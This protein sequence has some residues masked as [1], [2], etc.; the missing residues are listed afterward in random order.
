MSNQ[1]EQK[2]VLNSKSFANEM[3]INHWQT[4]K[5]GL[6]RHDAAIEFMHFTNSKGIKQYIAIL[7]LPHNDAPVVVELFS[8]ETLQDLLSRTK[9]ENDLSYISSVYDQDEESSNSLYNLVWSSIEPLLNNTQVVYFVPTGLLYKIS[10]QSIK[11]NNGALI[12]DQYDLIQMNSTNQIVTDG[13]TIR[14]NSIVMYGGVNYD[15]EIREDNKILSPTEVKTTV[16]NTSRSGLID[17]FHYLPGTMREVETLEEI[18]SVESAEIDVRSGNLAT[19][20]DFKSLSGNSPNVIHIST[21][22]FFFPDDLGTSK[23][24]D[25]GGIFRSTDNPLLRSG[26]AFSGANYAW[27]HGSNPHEE[28]DGILTAYEIS[29]LDLS[30]TDLV[31]LSACETGLGK[32]YGSEGVFGLQRAFKMA[33]VKNVIMS[34][35]QVNDYHT[36]ELMEMFYENWMEGHTVRKALKLA[37][38]TMSKIYPTYYWGAF[39]IVG[40]KENIAKTNRTRLYWAAGIF[41]LLILI[42]SVVTRIK[43][44]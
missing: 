40:E 8:E 38:Q 14:H 9:N 15:Y 3:N 42:R 44:V 32:V 43:Q 1:W 31:V 37:Q 4:I 26:L 5:E 28:E 16:S 21:H 39:V 12:S 35:W 36:T 18:L 25:K 19:E 17:R 23:K 22:G 7:I 41:L 10:F 34:L 11:N 6:K 33:G 30:N 20:S 2:L 27:K 13:N 24:V 29:N